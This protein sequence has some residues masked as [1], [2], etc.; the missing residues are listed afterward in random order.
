MKLSN[1]IESAGEMKE[2]KWNL[3]FFIIVQGK[4]TE[5]IYLINLKFI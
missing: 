4:I 1:K 2:A 5:R 3:S